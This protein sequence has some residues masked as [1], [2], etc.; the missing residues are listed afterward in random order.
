[1]SNH[2]VTLLIDYIKIETVE[3][4]FRPKSSLKIWWFTN[5]Y[6]PIRTEMAESNFD[7]KM[8]LNIRFADVIHS[9]YNLYSN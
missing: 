4:C 8:K 2:L 3:I 5:Y 9:A 7:R 6:K 1:M